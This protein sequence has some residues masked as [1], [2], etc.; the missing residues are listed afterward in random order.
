M[1][2]TKSRDI[3][4]RR[5]ANVALALGAFLF[6]VTLI[7]TVYA[8]I[9]KT[10]KPIPWV[11]VQINAR[12]S[13]TLAITCNPND[14]TDTRYGAILRAHIKRVCPTVDVNNTVQ[15]LGDGAGGIRTYIGATSKPSAEYPSSVQL[16]LRNV[17]WNCKVG[18]YRDVTAPPATCPGVT[19]LSEG[20]DDFPPP[21]EGPVL[22]PNPGVDCAATYGSGY[23]WNG[24]AN[25][26]TPPYYDESTGTENIDPSA[27][28]GG[29]DFCSA[30]KEINP[31][32]GRCECPSDRPTCTGGKTWNSNTCSCQHGSPILIDVL[33]DGF[34]LTDGAGGVAF[35]IN[36]D[37]TKERLSWTALSSDDAWLAL[38][39]D[40][41]GVIDNGQELFGNFTPQPPSAEPHG[42]LALAEFD[43]PGNGGN[44]DG[45]IDAGDA[46]Y[47][48]LRFWQDVNHN[49][50]SEQ[51][52]L[53]TLESLGVSLLH[54]S[55]KES[56][57][58]DEHGN[59]FRYRAKVDDAK[60]AKVNRWAWDVFLVAGR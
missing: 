54:L 47:I 49:G 60:G 15:F 24:F 41:N 44:G 5:A 39:R 42:F 10:D 55:Y 20:D 2:L 50:T 6:A 33:G 18:K 31:L 46:I 34:N 43:K 30:P 37:G 32:N 59:E 21:Y 36:S 14:P 28:G 13:G 23:S 51:S 45:V 25:T 52:E 11:N 27:G 40:G 7:T 17:F 58:T 56:K 9:I 4:K 16:N 38:D 1:N 22:Y 53:L 48:S 57:Q 26:C 3:H 35:D 19:M 8:G 29:G 12:A